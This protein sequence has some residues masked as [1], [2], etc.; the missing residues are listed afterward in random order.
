MIRTREIQAITFDAGGTLLFPHP[1][2]G[3]I[4]AEILANHGSQICPREL[5]QAF[6]QHW[7]EAII[8][9]KKEISH[10]F[11]KAWWRKVVEAT[12]QSIQ[13]PELS[14]EIFT[15]LWENFALP[16]RWRIRE[17]THEV[18]AELQKRGYHLGILSNWDGRLRP[19]LQRIGL[20]RYFQ[21]LFI[22]AEIGYEKPDPQAFRVCEKRFA[23]PPKAFLHI[24]D[25][26]THDF[27]AAQKAGWQ[28]LLLANNCTQFQNTE[29]LT[30][31]RE[32]LTMLEEKP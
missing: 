29:G 15:D 14:D 23:L 1:D 19:L 9:P 24:G 17:N 20:D 5:D 6:V 11:E 10:A 32:L 16:H 4:Y 21:D 7:R 18:L 28:S 25:S 31:L 12:L 27:K 2:V 30:D 22:S 26:R 8:E 3:T 13:G